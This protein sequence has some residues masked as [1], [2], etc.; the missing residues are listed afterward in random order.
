MDGRTDG[1]MDGW[2]DGQMDGWMD[3]RTGRMDAWVG[4]Q[5]VGW[6]NGDTGAQA[7]RLA[8]HLQARSRASEQ[9]SPETCGARGT[10]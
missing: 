10:C 8:P 9:H 7:R 2:M 6:M 5:V 1:W 3:E 4:G